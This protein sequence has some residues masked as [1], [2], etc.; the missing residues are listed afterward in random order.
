VTDQD[1]D[2]VLVEWDFGDGQS[3]RGASVTHVFAAPGTYQITLRLDDGRA[4]TELVGAVTIEPYTPLSAGP[5]SFA[6]VVGYASIAVILACA[7]AAAYLLFFSRKARRM[8]PEREAP[9][10]AEEE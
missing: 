9:G 2:A 4:A 6:A 1:G 3:D 7:A 10:S 5:S 8:D